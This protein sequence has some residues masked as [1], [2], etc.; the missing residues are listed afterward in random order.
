MVTNGKLSRARPE[1]ERLQRTGR[2]RLEGQYL[3]SLY[4]CALSQLVRPAPLVELA[5]AGSA[6]SAAKDYLG[7][8]PLG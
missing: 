3:E 1:A 7:T 5:P 6:A 4:I 8:A 2:A